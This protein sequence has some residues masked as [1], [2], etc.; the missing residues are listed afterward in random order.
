MGCRGDGRGYGRAIAGVP[1]QGR[2]RGEASG[3]SGERGDGVAD[4]HA[5]F[6][7]SLGILRYSLAHR[8]AGGEA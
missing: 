1:A 2:R 8:G 4:A 5:W 3:E 7:G 6:S